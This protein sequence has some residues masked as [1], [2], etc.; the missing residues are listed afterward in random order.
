[1]SNQSRAVRV[2]QPELASGALLR[3]RLSARDEADEARTRGGD[4]IRLPIVELR[5]D[6]LTVAQIRDR[7][8]RRLHRLRWTRVVDDHDRHQMRQR[9]AG[10]RDQTVQAHARHETVE[11]RRDVA[12]EDD[13]RGH[14]APA[15]SHESTAND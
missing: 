12:Q 4:R 1:M 3:N 11:C 5:R 10:N 13:E 7:V 9:D 2:R 8:K 15:T 14:C 6:V